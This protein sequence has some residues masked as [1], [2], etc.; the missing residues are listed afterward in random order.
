MLRKANSEVAARYP[1][2]IGINLQ[3]LFIATWND[4]AP[5]TGDITKRL[6][7]QSIMATDG[8]FSFAI[9]YYNKIE[10]SDGYAG[11]AKVGFDLGDGEQVS[12]V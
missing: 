9:F 10:F 7:F 2:L 3:W 6:T 8:F 1:G 11:H 12:L 5:F 4:V